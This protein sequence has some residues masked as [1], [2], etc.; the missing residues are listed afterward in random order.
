MLRKG[1]DK[2]QQKRPRHAQR[3][4]STFPREG[5]KGALPG[6][7]ATS[8]KQPIYTE[9]REA[10]PKML[11]RGLNEGAVRCHAPFLSKAAEQYFKVWREQSMKGRASS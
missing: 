2:Q 1:R 7:N 8:R 11:S 6:Q 3:N 4:I 5:P 10:G 9:D